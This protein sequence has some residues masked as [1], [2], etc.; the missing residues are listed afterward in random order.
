VPARSLWIQC[1]WGCLLVF[2]GTF[3][4]LTDMVVFAIFFYYGLTTLGVFIL[5]KKMPDAHRPYKVWGYPVVPA[6]FILFCI[7]L[8]INT[9]ITQPREAIFGLVLM[10]SGVPMYMWFTKKQEVKS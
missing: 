7:A 6:L 4:Q 1:I 5:R 8:I 3:D 10:L 2:T 9:I